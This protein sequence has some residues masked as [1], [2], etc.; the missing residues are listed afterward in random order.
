MAIG[1]DEMKRL[2]QRLAWWINFNMFHV[3]LHSFDRQLWLDTE[4]F[5]YDGSTPATGGTLGAG[6]MANGGISRAE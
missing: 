6:P 3:H 1:H 5:S 2:S 4:Q